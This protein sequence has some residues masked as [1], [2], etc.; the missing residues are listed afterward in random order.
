MLQVDREGSDLACAY[1]QATQVELE[2]R[3]GI[4]DNSKL[5]FLISL[6]TYVVT[7]H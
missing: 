4:K 2:I 5:I 7:P 1:L 3:G 6:K